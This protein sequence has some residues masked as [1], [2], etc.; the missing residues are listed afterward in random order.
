MIVNNGKR[1]TD[2]TPKSLRKRVGEPVLEV[3]LRNESVELVE[4]VRRISAVKAVTTNGAGR[5]L[6]TLD[7]LQSVTPEV[8]AGIVRSGGEILGVR[9]LVPSL[10]EIYLQLVRG[11]PT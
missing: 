2:G 4:S 9:A 5:L 3:T 1:I 10:E 7:D 8:V 6:V 11:N